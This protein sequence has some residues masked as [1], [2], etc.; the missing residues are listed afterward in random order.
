MKKVAIAFVAATMAIAGSAMVA[1]ANETRYVA[2]DIGVNVRQSATADS[3]RL[4]GLYR[5]DAVDVVA[6]LGNGWTQIN[7]GGGRAYV[8]SDCLSYTKPAKSK[9]YQE[10]MDNNYSSATDKQ[11]HILRGFGTVCVDNGYLALRSEPAY[12]Y[13][14]EIAHLYTGDKIQYAGDA[15][16]SYVTVYT[17]SGQFGWVNENYLR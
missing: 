1:S 14:N 16:G 17:E 5:G 12:A 3:A 13:E 15:C 8:I 6:E 11:S 7:Y 9:S 10:Y 2:N 4:G